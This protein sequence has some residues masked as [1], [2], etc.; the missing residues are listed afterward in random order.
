[1]ASDLDPEGAEPRALL[2]AADF[3]DA[4]VLEIG[5][6]DGRLT[7]RYASATRFVVGIE[8]T[9]SEAA[10]DACLA[11]LE[12]RLRFTRASAVA[13]PFRDEA[14]DVALFSWSL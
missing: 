3:T 11:D 13:L 8:P 1:M 6:G 9:V 12:G 2:E 10:A 5:S 4:R 14:F 7:L